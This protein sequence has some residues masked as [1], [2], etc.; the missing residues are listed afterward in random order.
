MVLEKIYNI[1]DK[2]DISDSE[3]SSD[4]FAITRMLPS[5]DLDK[6]LILLE[7]AEKENKKVVI[8]VANADE[9]WSTIKISDLILK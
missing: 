6:L 9:H 5:D 3:Y 8:N 4:L 7:K 2:Y 1:I